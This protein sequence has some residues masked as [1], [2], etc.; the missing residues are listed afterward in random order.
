MTTTSGNGD[1][2]RREVFFEIGAFTYGGA[3]T[4]LTPAARGTCRRRHCHFSDLL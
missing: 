1:G 4:W 2:G 3:A